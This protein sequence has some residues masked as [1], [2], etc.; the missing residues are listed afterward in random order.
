MKPIEATNSKQL[1]NASRNGIGSRS[2][3]PGGVTGSGDTSYDDASAYICVFP[4]V[5]QSKAPTRASAVGPLTNLD[6][7]Q[8]GFDAP[9]R[10]NH[11]IGTIVQRTEE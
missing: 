5:A 6:V 8:S 11:P 3:A 4:F 7:I 1:S 10:L 2:Q 9:K